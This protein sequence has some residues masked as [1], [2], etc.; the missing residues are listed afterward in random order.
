MNKLLFVALTFLSMHAFAQDK[1]DPRVFRISSSHTSFPDTGRAKGHVYDDVLYTAAEHYNDSSVLIVVPSQLELKRYV[2]I[3]CWFH[4]WRNNI[5]SVPARYDIIKQFIGSDRNAILVLAETAKDAPDSYGGK[6]EQKS[7]FKQLLHDVLDE[8]I[9]Q[10]VIDKKTKTG[11]VVLAGHSGAFRVMAYIL[12]NGGVE[13]NQAILF[14]ALYGEVDKFANWIQ[15]DKSHQFIDLY[16]N[17]GG[18]TDEVSEK[19]MQ[20]LGQK[21]IH[22]LKLEENEVNASILK[23]NNIIFIHSL[24]EHNDVINRPDYNFRLFIENSPANLAGKI[25]Q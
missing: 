11:K 21:K 20:L 9:K 19:M 24:K 4:G 1:S 17:K 3:I 25:G 14:D 6:L 18:G 16:T 2:D 10:K 5:D 12:Q 23:T 8:L 15:A 22:F 13:V 7:T